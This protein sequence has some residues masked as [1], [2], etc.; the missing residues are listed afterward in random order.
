M[1]SKTAA[2]QA[3]MAARRKE[4][5]DQE[6]ARLADEVASY[7]RSNPRLRYVEPAGIGRHGGVLLLRENDDGGR[8]KRRLVI[9]YSLNPKED[10]ALRNEHRWLKRLRG[11]EHIGQLVE[12]AD[13]SLELVSL[14][15]APRSQGDGQ[16]APGQADAGEA[17]PAA[18][19][20]SADD[21][22]NGRRPTLALE[23]VEHGTVFQW[24]RKLYGM[25]YP[26][27]I[28]NRILWS[29]LLCPMAYP[30]DG[31]DGAEPRRETIQPGRE[32]STLTQGS[33]HLNNVLISKIFPGDPDHSYAPLF[34]LIDFGRGMEEDSSRQEG[35]HIGY[36]TNIYAMAQAIET[37]MVPRQ[38][39]PLPNQREII[40][41]EDPYG[42]EIGT[43]A[44]MQMLTNQESDG[45]LRLLLGRCMA[46]DNQHVPPLSE[47]LER[48]ETAVARPAEYYANLPNG[49]GRYETDGAIRQFFEVPILNADEVG[50]DIDVTARFL[51]RHLEQVGF[52]RRTGNPRTMQVIY[53]R[54]VVNAANRPGAGEQVE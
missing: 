53:C 8:M 12:L 48:C 45:D 22:D 47:V 27:G 4:L 44:S 6:N 23:Y 37:L 21:K 13:A 10:D 9:K 36:I 7:F 33:G 28:P 39:L 51:P 31:P 34:K 54:P 32:P 43:V 18:G 41:I 42:N 5:E 1:E 15:N 3:V 35:V 24:M 30:P 38:S 20:Q 50:M 29:L 16:T 2:A 25:G 46:V 49:A 40:D 17:G 52:F 11:A 14:K 19:N 26:A